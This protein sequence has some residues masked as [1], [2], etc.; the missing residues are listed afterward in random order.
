VPYLLLVEVLETPIGSEEQETKGRWEAEEKPIEVP[1]RQRSP[2]LDIDDEDT[3]A[4]FG[5]AF[6]KSRKL[7]EQNAA[8]DQQDDAD[9]LYKP[10][11]LQ[12]TADD[13]ASSNEDN[14]STR[15]L[16]V[17]S[18]GEKHTAPSIAQRAMARLHASSTVP[19][20]SMSAPV[21]PHIS[22]GHGSSTGSLAS[23]DANH[24][25]FNRVIAR[26]A[27]N[28]AG[29]DEFSERMRTAAVMLAQLAEQSKRENGRKSHSGKASSAGGGSKGKLAT[30]AIRE[31]IVR[32]MTALEEERLRKMH[33]EGVSS[34][35]GGSGGE[36]GGGE[37]IEDERNLMNVIKKDKDDP[38]GKSCAG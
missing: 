27:S 25:Y 9:T 34:G 11:L 33:T 1:P 21:S 18:S 32:E 4:L 10:D 22:T 30:Q 35:M 23:S 14:G 7:R 5:G 36:G 29:T 17:S 20:A 28:S 12:G 38:S 37:M 3:D 24:E 16:D 6:Y 2:S 13:T 15:A 19:H 31:R 26:R 8:K